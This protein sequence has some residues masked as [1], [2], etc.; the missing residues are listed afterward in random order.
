MVEILRQILTG[1]FDI[2]HFAGHGDYDPSDPSN[3]GWIFGREQVLR[4]TDIFR[5]RRVPRLV[6][7]NACFSGVIQQGRAQASD[8]MSRGLAT[9][10]QAFFERGVPN[11][12]GT[13]WPVNDTQ[14]STFAA[15]FYRQVLDEATLS[16]A[17]QEARRKIFDESLGSTWGAYQL[18]GNPRDVL[19]RLRTA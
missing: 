15:E 2:V 14:A 10:A 7:A 13:G 19:V 6:F 16:K 4:A 18:Y 3:A 5:A 9:I 17:M 12:L 8:E 11:Y 1:E